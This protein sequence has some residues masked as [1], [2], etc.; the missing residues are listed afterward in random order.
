M[1]SRQSLAYSIL[2]RT[3]LSFSRVSALFLIT[4]EGV[5]ISGKEFLRVPYFSILCRAYYLKG[6]FKITFGDSN[7]IYFK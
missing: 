7:I 2:V 6:L 5:D 1:A 3:I 4:T